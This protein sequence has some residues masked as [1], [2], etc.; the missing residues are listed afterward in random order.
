[1]LGVLPGL[2]GTVQATEALK[3]VLG[4]G[5]VLSG[6]LWLLDALTMQIRTLRFSR[7]PERS[8]LSLDTA[9][10]ADYQDLDCAAPPAAISPAELRRLLSSPTPP[11]LLDVR[12]PAEFEAQHLPGAVLLPLGQLPAGAAAVPRTQPVVVYCRSGARSARAI[13]QLQADFGF[14]NLV[15][16]E[17]GLLAWNEKL[18]PVTPASPA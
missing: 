17:G 10:P 15:N 4:L 3:V 5:E 16:L 7:H 1:M 6:R 12:E 9:D 11:F 18:A 14:T 8:H 2:V 13:Q